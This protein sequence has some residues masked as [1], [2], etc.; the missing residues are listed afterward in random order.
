MLLKILK[1]VNKFI[2]GSTI[3]KSY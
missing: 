1:L 3:I 2:I